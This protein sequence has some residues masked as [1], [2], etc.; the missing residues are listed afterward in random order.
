MSALFDTYEFRA[1]VA[2]S[3]V[4]SLPIL[5]TIFSCIPSANGTW[6]LLGSGV[7]SLALLYGFTLLVS[8]RG[9]AIEP[10]LWESW[11]GAP[12]TRFLRW[13]DGT[14][15]SDLKE[16]IRDSV[17]KYWEIHLLSDTQ[18]KADPATAD[19]LIEKTFRQVREFLRLRDSKGLWLKQ[20]AEYGFARNL[21]GCRTLFLLLCVASIIGGG[22]I[23]LALEKPLQGMCTFGPA[24]LFVVWLPLGWWLLPKLAKEAADRYA[25]TAWSTFFA[26]TAISQ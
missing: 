12:S 22:T 17:V 7:V 9:R 20:N 26:L 19:E 5:V 6:P 18:E 23:R 4:V 25:N 8:S 3:V 24:V 14:L 13:R 2:P 15:D 1:R 21:L 11:D 10:R 16:K